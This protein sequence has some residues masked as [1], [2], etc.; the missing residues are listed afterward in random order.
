ML[1]K[2][3]GRK[4]IDLRNVVKIFYE[5]LD[6]LEIKGREQKAKSTDTR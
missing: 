6:V 4:P 2:G 5:K 1:L 3:L